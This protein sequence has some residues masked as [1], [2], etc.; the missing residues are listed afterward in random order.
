[1][2]KLKVSTKKL[3]SSQN[4]YILQSIHDMLRNSKSVSY[5]TCQIESK[6]HSKSQ[7]VAASVINGEK[8]TRKDWQKHK[9][10]DVEFIWKKSISGH[11]TFEYRI[12]MVFNDLTTNNNASLDG[13]WF[14]QF[15]KILGILGESQNQELNGKIKMIQYQNSLRC[16]F[17][18]IV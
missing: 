11:G 13:W 2:T 3:I 15:D 14:G 4:C 8:R 7:N 16:I 12:M 1:M 18:C 9:F 10:I 6:W 17:L 5:K